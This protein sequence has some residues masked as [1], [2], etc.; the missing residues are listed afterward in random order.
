MTAFPTP[1]RNPS[2]PAAEAADYRVMEST[3]TPTPGMRKVPGWAVVMGVWTV[4]GLISAAQQHASYSLSR[5]TALPWLT[6]LITQMPLAYACALATPGIHWLGRRFP[7]ERRKWP[8]SLAVHLVASLVFVLVLNI[9]Y[10]YYALPL[11]PPPPTPRPI[12]DRA[13]ALVV[14]WALADTMLYC[15]ILS[16]SVVVDHQRRL[17]ARELSAS[18]LETQLARAELQALQMQL[19]PHFLFNALHTVGA[20][21]RT[22]DRDTA[23]RVVTGLGDLLRRVLDRASQQEVPLRQELEFARNYLEIE[24]IRFRDRLQ[25]EIDAD[26]EVLEA[27]VPHLLL[28]PLIENAIRHGITPT[29][30]ACLVRVEAGRA[31]TYLC[32][33][34]RDDGAATMPP[35]GNRPTEGIG[36]A[37]TR[38]RLTRLYGEEGQ[39]EFLPVHPRG[40]EVRIALPYRQGNGRGRH[41]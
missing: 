21:V 17:R 40:H 1:R 29:P 13:M 30:G 32:L 24:Q 4:Y 11:L 8:L 2:R 28:Q 7:F 20:L 33:V 12:W 19:Q 6:S 38:A 34:V 14:S 22:G 23:I 9:G 27:S 5:G 10:A 3:S 41:P 25:V 37:N 26:P 15:A 31:G 36:L 35:A 16:V 18:Q 39:L